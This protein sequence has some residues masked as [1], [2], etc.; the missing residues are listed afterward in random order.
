MNEKKYITISKQIKSAIQRNEFGEKLPGVVKLAEMFESNPRTI[1][2]A[3]QLLEKKGK[4]TINGTRGTYVSGKNQRPNF[5]IIGVIGLTNTRSN[6]LEMKAIQSIASKENYRVVALSDSTELDKIIHE[7][8][9]FL[10]NFPADGFIFAYSSITENIVATLRQAG[11][12]FVSMNYVSDVLGVNW[13]DF[14]SQ[15]GFKRIL[16]EFTNSGHRK[17][18]FFEFKNRYYDYSQRMYEV[19]R[20]FMIDMDEFDE[21]FYYCPYTLGEYYAKHGENSYQIFAQEIVE[22]VMALKTRPT[23]I[24]INASVVATKACELF[25]KA[26]LNVPGDISVAGEFGQKEQC[27][28]SGVLF[29]YS[30]RA[31]KATETITA[32]LKNPDTP[33]TQKL[34]EAKWRSG[35]TIGPAYAPLR[36]KIS[37]PKAHSTKAMELVYGI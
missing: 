13:V 20:N 25:R 16:S 33:L 7:N 23:A 21:R 26:G 9:E 30:L 3:L 29:D 18:A 36:S 22:Y 28:T 27:S 31:T 15:G 37:K 14:D 2:K 5:R 34:F 1:S 24:F 32:L 11:I 10:V 12:P 35:N 17:I 8:P 19:Y 4:V 6:G